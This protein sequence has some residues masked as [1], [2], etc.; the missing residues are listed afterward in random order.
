MVDSNSSLKY[1]TLISQEM[2]KRGFLASNLVFSS[3]AH[4]NEIHS[5]YLVALDNIFSLIAKC[6]DGSMLIDD[7]LDGPVCHSG[8]RRLN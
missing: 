8:F 2:L 4:T 7:L 1:K 5:E 6:E 3:V